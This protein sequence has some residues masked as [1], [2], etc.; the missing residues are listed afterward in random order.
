VL[1]SLQN[2]KL[3]PDQHSIL[4]DWVA[5]VAVH[6][7]QDVEPTAAAAAAA[8]STAA[9]SSVGAIATAA[10]LPSL[11]LSTHVLRLFLP[12][13][14]SILARICQHKAHTASEA[15]F[16]HAANILTHIA[17]ICPSR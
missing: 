13:M 5:R 15:A 8:A 11:A 7:A 4:V 16:L 17:T 1:P 14:S 10:A 2:I 3:V 9:A 6:P 12:I